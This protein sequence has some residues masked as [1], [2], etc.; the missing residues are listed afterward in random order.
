[1]TGPGPA[2]ITTIVVGVDGSPNSRAATEWA[3]GLAARLGA[4]VV[5]VHALGL[6]EQ[7]EPGAQ[8]QPAEAHVPE[9]DRMFSEEWCAPL[10]G[11]GVAHRREMRYGPPVQVLLEAAEDENADLLVV[12]S[13]GCGG[14]SALLLGSTSSRLANA[15][16]RPVVI[17][18]LPERPARARPGAERTAATP[19]AGGD[20]DAQL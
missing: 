9:I 16:G 17:V 15:S 10:A 11:A 6:L 19:A 20:R 2:A 7:M 12:G 14:P 1:M 5:A 13:R 4:V 3:A 18:P 8:P